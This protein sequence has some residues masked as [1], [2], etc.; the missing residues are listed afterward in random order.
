VI[1]EDDRPKSETDGQGRDDD[2]EQKPHGETP[3]LLTLRAGS[4]D[5]ETLEIRDRS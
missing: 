3:R 4:L 5:V 1:F 2:E